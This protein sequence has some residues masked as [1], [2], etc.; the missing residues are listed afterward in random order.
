MRLSGWSELWA[1]ATNGSRYTHVSYCEGFRMRPFIDH[2]FPARQ[3]R[4]SKTFK[5]RNRGPEGARLRRCDL[6][7]LLQFCPSVLPYP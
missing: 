6:C 5:A 2:C 3:G 1:S 4:R 7:G